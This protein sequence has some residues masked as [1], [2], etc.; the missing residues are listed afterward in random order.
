M[1]QIGGCRVHN[2]DE[3]NFQYLMAFISESEIGCEDE[4][5]L[6][7]GLDGKYLL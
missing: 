4:Y 6:R 5:G 1:L 7:I 3:V 2:T